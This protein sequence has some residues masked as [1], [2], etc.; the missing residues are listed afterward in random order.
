MSSSTP[1]SP[2][3]SP[4]SISSPTSFSVPSP[5]GRSGDGVSKNAGVIAGSVV[6]GVGVLAITFVAVFW[7]LKRNRRHPAAPYTSQDDTNLYYPPS[8]QTRK[9]SKVAWRV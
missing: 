4:P 3:S 6:G 7:V 2:G 8:S 9:S 1:A 5:S